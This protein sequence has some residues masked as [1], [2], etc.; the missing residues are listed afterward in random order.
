MLEK[1]G[2]L[3]LTQNDLDLFKE[4]QVSDRIRDSWGLTYDQ[5]RDSIENNEF[6]VVTTDS[7]STICRYEG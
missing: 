4:G 7:N 1:R 3:L 5:L 2:V 6:E